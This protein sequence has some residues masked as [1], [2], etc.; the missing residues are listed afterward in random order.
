MAVDQQGSVMSEVLGGGLG[1]ALGELSVG[2]ALESLRLQVDGLIDQLAGAEAEAR[3]SPHERERPETPRTAPETEHSQETP[4]TRKQGDREQ[5]GRQGGPAGLDH[6]HGLETEIESLS[7]KVES[8]TDMLASLTDLLEAQAERLETLELQVGDPD[9]DRPLSREPSAVVFPSVDAL[10]AEEPLPAESPFSAESPLREEALLGE[11]EHPV[12]A[13]QSLRSAASVSG[14]AD[15]AGRLESIELK[16]VRLNNNLASVRIRVD[17]FG[18]L[19]GSGRAVGLGAGADPDE[20][21]SGRLVAPETEAAE[22]EPAARPDETADQAENFPD[23]DQRLIAQ[24]ADRELAVMGGRVRQRSR[25]RR[26]VLVVDS[27]ADARTVLSIYLSRTGYQVVT[28]SSAEDC[29][30]KLCYHDVD[31]VVLEPDMPGADG[32]HVCSIIRTDPAFKAYSRVPIILYT[33]KPQK[34]DRNTA[35]R[36]QA[37]DYVVKG[38]DM[39]PLVSALLQSCEA[40]EAQDDTDA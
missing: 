18:R 17:D 22:P 4:G 8:A 30:S 21:A 23:L 32:G 12:E 26:N 36:W 5:G 33:S 25:S 16:I 37:S 13:G 15:L 39:L 14:A 7:G 38:G 10:A 20:T 27:S 6:A 19:L 29:L 9:F 3:V 24:L 2:D 1:K 34:F 11:E 40:A 31:A 28:A 35:E